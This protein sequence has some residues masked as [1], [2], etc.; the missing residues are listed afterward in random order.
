MTCAGRSWPATRD[1]ARIS[2]STNCPRTLPASSSSVCS[3]RRGTPVRRDDVPAAVGVSGYF[4]RCPGAGFEELTPLPVALSGWGSEHMRGSAVTGALARSAEGAGGA[5]PDLRPVRF[6]ADLQR[7]ATMAP[8]STRSTVVREG[9]RLLLVDSEFLQ[10]GHIMARARTLFLPAEHREVAD[11][12]WSPGRSPSMPPTDQRPATDEGRLF[13]SEGEG[14]NADAAAHR[15][16]ARKQLWC[17]PISVVESESVSPFQAAAT[18]ADLTN[19]VTHWG[20]G[21]VRH[22]NADVTLTLA[23]FPD[24]QALGVSATGRVGAGA[25]SV[26]TAEMYD[27]RGVFGHTVVS[28]ILQSSRPVETITQLMRGSRTEEC[29]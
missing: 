26:G 1:R 18:V 13:F 25:I 12:P 15:N 23:R 17:Q 14:W 9:R 5:R 3:N 6:T 7:A 8:V 27:H 11:P 28:T 2:H 21:G 29:A 22:I 24:G 4:R 10:S 19:L 16:S 20:T